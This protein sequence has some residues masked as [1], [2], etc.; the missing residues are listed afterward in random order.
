[1]DFQGIPKTFLI[2]GAVAL[3]LI[4]LIGSAFRTVGAG[5]VGVVKRFGAVQQKGLE[6][7]LHFV[8]PFGIDT[9]T[10]MNTRMQSATQSGAASSQ[11][12]QTVTT[13]VSIQW[14]VNKAYAP[15]LLQRVGTTVQIEGVIIN[16]ALS[17]SVKAVTAKYT[18]QQLVTKRELVKAQIKSQV[19]SFMD[20]TML[21]K[22]L[23]LDGG[24]R[25]I[26]ISNIAITDFE[27]S[28]EFNR[29]IEMKVKAEQQA[30]QAKE[31]KER[32]ITQAQAASEEKKIAA[33][34]E[35]IRIK[36]IA[37]AK[38]G[39]IRAEA[40]A[41]KDNP[42]LIQ[43]RLAEKW[44]GVLPRFN[45]GGGN[46]LLNIDSLMNAGKRVARNVDYEKLAKAI[47]V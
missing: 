44:N 21:S 33:A 25:A 27:F 10:N 22:D 42:Q 3:L 30:L 41:L 29:A 36:S 6:E 28:A 9:V 19:T 12:L 26:I 17:E 40:A 38:A 43:L 45:G 39:A 15:Q 47:D 46:T 2:I 14:F 8:Y 7:G 13:E 18:A 35:A 1:M 23:R 37:Q 11:D 24:S 5:E 32:I 31:E 16:P 4:I 20:A 34:A